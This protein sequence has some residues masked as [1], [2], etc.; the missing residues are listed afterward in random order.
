[1]DAEE[2]GVNAGIDSSE[3]RVPIRAA[4]LLEGG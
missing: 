1:M 3:V 4:G 2:A